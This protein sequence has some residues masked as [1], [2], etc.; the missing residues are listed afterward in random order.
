MKHA[1][2]EAEKAFKEDEIPVGV[3]YSIRQPDNSK[4]SQPE[5][6]VEGSDSPCRDDCNY[7]GCRLS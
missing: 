6:N 1:L 5:R 7:S 3:G 2:L 4:G